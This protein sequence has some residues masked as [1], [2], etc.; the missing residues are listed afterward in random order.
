MSISENLPDN[1]RLAVS[2]AVLASITSSALSSNVCKSPIPSNLEMNLSGSRVSNASNP[3]PVPTK[4][5]GAFVTA[6]ADRAPPPFAEPSNLVKI[7]PL[8][9]TASW[10]A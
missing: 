6:T 4:I 9:P 5:I 8:T 2:S 3:S 7:T 1:I 10:N